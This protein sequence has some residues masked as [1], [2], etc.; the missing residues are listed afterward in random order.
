M[1]AAER[2]GLESV[3]LRREHNASLEL[4]VEPTVE[5]GGLHDLVDVLASV[6]TTDDGRTR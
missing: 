2:A 6:E 1:I 3:F 5:I 4:G